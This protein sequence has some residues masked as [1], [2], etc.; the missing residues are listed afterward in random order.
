[1]EKMGQHALLQ[2]KAT[3]TVAS[4]HKSTMSRDVH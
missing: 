2:A 3:K 4:E 1:M